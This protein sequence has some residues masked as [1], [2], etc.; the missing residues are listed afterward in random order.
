MIKSLYLVLKVT[1]LS[2]FLVN[3]QACGE[4]PRRQLNDEP[5]LKKPVNVST[6]IPQPSVLIKPAKKYNPISSLQN[7]TIVDIQV[8]SVE[9]N[10]NQIEVLATS[11][12]EKSNKTS[13]TLKGHFNEFGKAYLL[14]SN[15]KNLKATSLCIDIEDCRKLIVDFYLL[16]NESRVRQFIVNAKVTQKNEPQPDAPEDISSNN[17]SNKLDNEADASYLKDDI[18][19]KVIGA[20]NIHAD[21]KYES[22]GY[23]G[24]IPGKDFFDDTPIS[25]IKIDGGSSSQVQ[26]QPQTG[27]TTQIPEPT[28]EPTPVPVQTPEAIAATPEPSPVNNRPESGGETINVIEKSIP[29]ATA[30]KGSVVVQTPPTLQVPPEAPKSTPAPQDKEAPALPDL[31]SELMFDA[32][33][34]IAIDYYS[35]GKLH[36][37]TRIPK[38]GDGYLK[39]NRGSGK[40]FGSGL[41]V[42]FLIKMAATFKQ[43]YPDT[44]MYINGLS[45]QK[46]GQ[47]GRHA[48]HQNGLDVDISYLPGHQWKFTSVISDKRDRIISTRTVGA[49]SNYKAHKNFDFKR[50]F[51]FFKMIVDTKLV[52]RIFVN[53]NLKREFCKWGRNQG[54]DFLKLNEEVFRRL[55]VDKYHHDHFHLRLKCHSSYSRC[56]KQTEP[57]KGHGC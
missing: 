29:A 50:N 1:I 24:I 12:D 51:D 26:A 15:Y 56:D 9:V 14:N 41:L 25:S 57:P 53:T 44:E 7:P 38:E 31:N 27:V 33:G 39:I 16:P 36:N 49:S 52:N 5:T 22:D 35:K 13:H 37:S 48:S 34:G 21:D 55:R 28:P 2:L 47:V 19:L 6:K 3:I 45:G 46:G 32:S 30:P 54:H 8:D 10:N 4:K 43:I 40:N 23:V 42:D 18:V 20:G 11:F 17:G